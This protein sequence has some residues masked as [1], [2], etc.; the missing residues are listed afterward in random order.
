[1]R[2]AATHPLDNSK[3]SA[4]ASTTARSSIS[5]KKRPPRS[6]ADRRYTSSGENAQGGSRLRPLVHCA[7]ESDFAALGVD[8]S[9][10]AVI[11]R[12]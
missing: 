12:W 11:A 3:F 5:E 6:W 1:M 9:R 8:L 7:D 2:P 10:M 4:P